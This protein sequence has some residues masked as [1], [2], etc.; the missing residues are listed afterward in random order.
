MADKTF[1]EEHNYADRCCNEAEKLE[2]AQQIVDLDKE[3]KNPVSR[4]VQRRIAA[5]KGEPAPDFSKPS[6]TSELLTD[7]SNILED[8]VSERHYYRETSVGV[9]QK[10]LAKFQPRIN[11]LETALNDDATDLWRVTNAIK[12]EIASRE[13]IMEGR[14][15]YEWDDNRYKDETRLAF[16]AVLNLIKNVQHPAQLRFRKVNPQCQQSQQSI[17]EDER[18]KIG[19]WYAKRPIGGGRNGDHRTPLSEKEIANLKA[20]LPP[21]SQQS[22]TNKQEDK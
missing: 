22:T 20:G 2:Q 6:C 15:C 8:Y 13:W 21:T 7:I 1:Y 9:A 16:E 5:Q 19:E 17:R 11:E 10:I 12:K 14:G 18:R 4:S 3:H